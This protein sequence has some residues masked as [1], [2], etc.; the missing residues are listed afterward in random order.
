MPLLWSLNAFTAAGNKLALPSTKSNK[1]RLLT[2]LFTWTVGFHAVL[3]AFQIWFKFLY[4]LKAG[5]LGPSTV[6]FIWKIFS[7]TSLGINLPARAPYVFCIVPVLVVLEP[8]L[9]LI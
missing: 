7:Y 8:L 5:L 9:N 4:A 6:L 3:L 1:T 2:I